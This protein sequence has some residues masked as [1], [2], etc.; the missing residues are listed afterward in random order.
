[1]PSDP[2][3]P[4]SAP[5][6]MLLATPANWYKRRGYLH[7]DEE[8]SEAAALALASSTTS[9]AG[10][11]FL[12][13]L[14]FSRTVRK[15]RGQPKERAIHYASH[16]D[17]H[18]YSFYT[19]LLSAPYEAELA[20]RGLGECVLAYRQVHTGPGSDLNSN[21][22]FATDIFAEVRQRGDCWA[23]CFDVTKFFDTIR[24]RDLKQSWKRLLDGKMPDDHFAVF[25]SLTSYAWVDREKL[26]IA[27]GLA[28]TIFDGLRPAWTRE[29]KRLRQLAAAATRPRVLCSPDELRG[30][31]ATAL[32]VEKRPLIL[33][34]TK[35]FGIPQ[36][37]PISAM[38]SNLYLLELDTALKQFA[39]AT[40]G[41]YRRYC[42]DILL[43]V[44]DGAQAQAKLLVE[45]Q[46]RLLGLALNLKKTEEICFSAGNVDPAR[47]LP[48]GRTSLQYLGLTFD[49]L[50]I[51]L[52]HQ[53]IARFQGK[54]ARAVAAARRAGSHR[55]TGQVCVKPLLRNFSH[56][57]QRN[58]VS[59]A[60]RAARGAGEPGILKQVG[61]SVEVIV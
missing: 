12:P 42:D 58:F 1:M 7:F 36:G 43:I 26:R 55:K 53:S 40:G 10:H 23:L 61:R 29:A 19:R 46:L 3:S 47:S 57:G 8:L 37:S 34:H 9:V 48:P 44:P 22:R 25:K 38:L 30:H 24:H 13:F 54:R 45:T 56:L 28:K 49:G 14:H 5:P 21:I 41:V 59:Y 20:R 32:A 11:A 35:P 2:D 31:H 6:R 17:S 50:R 33:Q 51:R 60:K 16:A 18:I 27:A 15:R 52:R 39:D 4:G